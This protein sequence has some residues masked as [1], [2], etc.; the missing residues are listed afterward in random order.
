MKETFLKNLHEARV[1][2][3]RA[4]ARLMRSRRRGDAECEAIDHDT[5]K[6]TASSISYWS[7]LIKE[8]CR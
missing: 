5:L 4:L 2:H 7:Q 6:F 3:G 1:A 8:F